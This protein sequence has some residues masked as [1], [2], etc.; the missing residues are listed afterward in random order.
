[1]CLPSIEHPILLTTYYLLPTTYYLLLT[2]YY[3]ALLTTFYILFTKGV[4][5]SSNPALRRAASHSV[6]KG[7]PVPTLRP[8]GPDSTDA[9]AAEMRAERAAE[10]ARRA[11][12]RECQSLTTRVG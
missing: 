8:L 2:T 3:V 9:G 11:A 5:T 12:L 1:M 4:A 10:R 7:T 6:F